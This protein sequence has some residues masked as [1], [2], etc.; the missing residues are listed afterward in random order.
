ML[1]ARWKRKG[2][3]QRFY[4]RNAVNT[5]LPW[6]GGVSCSPFRAFPS[7]L[8]LR[9]ESHPALN[10]LHR[11]SLR[12]FC[13]PVRLYGNA[14]AA[15]H[16]HASTAG[17]SCSCSGRRARRQARLEP[18]RPLL[19]GFA[20]SSAD[21]HEKQRLTLSFAIPRA[22]GRISCAGPGRLATSWPSSKSTVPAANS[23]RAVGAGLA[24][25]MGGATGTRRRRRARQQVRCGRTAP[26]GR[27]RRGTVPASPSSGAATIPPCN[28]RGFPASA[29]ACRRA[30]RRSAACWIA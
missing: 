22:A 15:R 1:L 25:R 30:A 13:A 10:E 2:K 24:A 26:P 16:P 7:A 17:I 23:I 8:F 14:G 4:A 12:H 28:S 5:T 6:R 29:T 19:S 27:P 9:P 18:G 21:S 11:R 3:R 20:F